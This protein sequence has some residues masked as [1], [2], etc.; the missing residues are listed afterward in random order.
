MIIGNQFFLCNFYAVP[1]VQSTMDLDEAIVWNEEKK[2]CFCCLLFYT[3]CPIACSLPFF[4][5]FSHL[6]L[7]VYVCEHLVLSFLH[8]QLFKIN[9]SSQCRTL[10]TAWTKN[11]SA[12][13][14]MLCAIHL[15]KRELSLNKFQ[16]I[17]YNIQMHTLYTFATF[18]QT[19]K[20][21][22]KQSLVDW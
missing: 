14:Y 4:P 7:G 16:C 2:K 1:V 3:I 17:L 22:G 18:I 11:L 21:K 6:Y 12:M 5:S 15:N 13:L 19:P 20:Y 8:H 9:M 10:R